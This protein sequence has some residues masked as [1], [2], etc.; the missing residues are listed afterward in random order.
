MNIALIDGGYF[1]K[2]LQKHWL[3]DTYG[4]MKFWNEV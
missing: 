2:R 3:P 4:N 1:V